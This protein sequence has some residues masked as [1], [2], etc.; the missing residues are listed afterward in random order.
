MKL[1]KPQFKSYIKEV[2]MEIMN[3]LKIES[4]NK[5]PLEQ[6]KFKS[7]KTPYSKEIHGIKYSKDKK[8][9]SKKRES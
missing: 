2:I 6:N 5:K 3:E 7:K 9:L 4:S 1:T 8:P